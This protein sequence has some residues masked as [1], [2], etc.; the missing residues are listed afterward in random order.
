MEKTFIQSRNEHLKLLYIGLIFL[1]NQSDSWSVLLSKY[2]YAFMFLFFLFLEITNVSCYLL[3]FL[4]G[5]VEHMMQLLC[6]CPLPT[7]NF[8]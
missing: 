7:S 4:V 8:M 6:S 3:F 2:F 5:G 1:I